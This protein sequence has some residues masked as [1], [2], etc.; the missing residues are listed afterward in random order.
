[1][2]GMLD[3]SGIKDVQRKLDTPLM[4]GMADILAKRKFNIPLWEECGIFQGLRMS[5]GRVGHS[6]CGRNFG[7][8]RVSRESRALL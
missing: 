1:M 2:G 5:R 7:H 6:F 8:S 3:I 4:G